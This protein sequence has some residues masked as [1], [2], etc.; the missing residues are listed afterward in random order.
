MKTRNVKCPACGT[1]QEVRMMDHQTAY[2]CKG[3]HKLVRAMDVPKTAKAE[4]PKTEMKE[5]KKEQKQEKR[6][7]RRSKKK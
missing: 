5:D 1:E 4:K 3:C 6:K 2:R 7:S